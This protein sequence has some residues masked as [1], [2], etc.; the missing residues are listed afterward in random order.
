M[1]TLATT[2]L[3]A[4]LSYTPPSD[5]GFVVHLAF[6]VSMQATVKATVTYTDL[7]GTSRSESVLNNGLAPDAYSVVPVTVAAAGGSAISLLVQASVQNAVTVT[8]S[9]EELV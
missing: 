1:G 7:G 6:V 9:I 4:V 3:T 8:A 2:A 5:G